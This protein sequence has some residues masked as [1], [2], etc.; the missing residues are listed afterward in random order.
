MAREGMCSPRTLDE[1]DEC[2]LEL[3]RM[4]THAG[5]GACTRISG[6][7]LLALTVITLAPFLFFVLRPSLLCCGKQYNPFAT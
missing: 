3:F 1:S 5:E 6:G 4:N 7:C 2:A